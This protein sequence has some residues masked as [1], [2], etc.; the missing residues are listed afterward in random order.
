[1]ILLYISVLQIIDDYFGR[2][3]ASVY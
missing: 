3:V 2:M 1:M